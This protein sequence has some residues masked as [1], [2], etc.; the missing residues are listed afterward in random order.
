MK[1]LNRVSWFF[2]EGN[3]DNPVRALNFA[4]NLLLSF[5]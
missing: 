1:A 2:K 4:L 3:L 5:Y